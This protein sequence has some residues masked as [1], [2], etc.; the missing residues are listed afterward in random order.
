MRT[1]HHV[2]KWCRKS[3]QLVKFALAVDKAVNSAE[4]KK[5]T[6]LME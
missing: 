4:K 1:N 5:A 3:G 2:L 6:I